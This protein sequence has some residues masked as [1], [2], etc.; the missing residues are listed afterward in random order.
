M[1]VIQGG[2]RALLYII[3]AGLVSACGKK[4]PECADTKAS[5]ALRNS[6]NA[7]VVEA[8]PASRVNP[9]EDKGGVI[10]KYL[11][12]WT[13][14]L[15]NVTSSGYDEKSKTRS[16]AGKVTVTIPDTKQ[17]AA[18]DVGYEMQTLEDSKSGDFELRT[19][20][21]FRRFS[22]G[23]S[24]PVGNHYK[25]Y[26]VSGTWVGQSTC[27]PT[28]VQENLFS[29]FP[30]NQSANGFTV[31]SSDT[32]WQPDEAAANIPLKVVIDGGKAT[33]DITAPGGKS[34]RRIG[35]LQPNQRFAMTENDEMKTAISKEAYISSDGLIYDSRSPIQVRAR[36]RSNATGTELD[37]VLTRICNMKL[38]KQ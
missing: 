6:M 9:A 17:S 34:I 16:C 4:P 12:T 29:R 11:A 1:R 2:S 22:F 20:A 37:G 24:E 36:V 32:P 7:W 27:T 28:Q 31:L 8:L 3:A 5:D 30:E 18:L 25:V 23:M 26:G 38:H 33:V 21:N 15:S 35:Q 13:F 10:P 14:A 19:S